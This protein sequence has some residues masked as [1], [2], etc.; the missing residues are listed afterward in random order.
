MTERKTRFDRREFLVSSTAALIAASGSF[1]NGGI[2]KVAASSGIEPYEI[3][4]PDAVLEDLRE[5]LGRT[6]FPDQLEG[7]EWDYGTELSYLQELCEYWLKD[8][9]WRAQERALNRFGHYRT[10]IDDLGI[11]FIHQRSKE[12]N[13]F[14]LVITHGWPGSIFEFMKI[15]DPL[16]DP[17]AH[18]GRA[19]DAFHVVC[20]SMPGYGFSDAPRKP[21][22]GSKQVA[23]TVAKLMAKLGYDAYGAQG[24]DWGAMISTWLG[25]L[26]ADHVRGIHLNMVIAQPPKGT[27]AEMIKGL[28][29]EEVRRLGEAQQFMKNETGYQAIQS[30]KPQSLGYGLNDSPSGLA[31]W[32]V[33]KFRT[34]SDCDGVV[35]NKFTKDELLTNI[36]IYWVT[37]SITSSTR[38]Y[39]EGMGDWALTAGR[40]E[41]PT[42]CALFPVELTRPPRQWVEKSYNVTH[43]TEM[44]SGGHFAAMEEP[45]LLVEDVRAFFRG[46]RE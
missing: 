40:I 11:H 12:K 24:G 31:A 25:L 3:N 36:M 14:P 26:D 41:V 5:R 43:W 38:L 21:G 42:G 45:E 39:Y 37:E 19:E 8:Y 15:I 29:P 46:L 34:W 16:V 17:V 30:T 20:P 7:A 1:E 18:G 13:A 27:P 33:E 44:P 22:F 2:A 28:T 23:E 9:D 32:I 4:V 6:R 35:E 10:Q